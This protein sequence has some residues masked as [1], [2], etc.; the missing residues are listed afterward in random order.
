[1]LGIYYS[2]IITANENL[3]CYKVVLM[4]LKAELHFTLF[5][6]SS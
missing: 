6:T 4:A 5:T 2:I 3:C 1:M